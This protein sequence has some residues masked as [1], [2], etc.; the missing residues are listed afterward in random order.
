MSPDLDPQTLLK[1]AE[2]HASRSVRIARS[3]LGKPEIIASRRVFWRR[4]SN[5]M[6]VL[7]P[8][9]LILV[10]AGSMIQTHSAL[11]E[12]RWE[13]TAAAMLLA[14]VLIA[15]ADSCGFYLKPV[16]TSQTVR[17]ELLQL[18]NRSA[19]ARAWHEFV[20]QEGRPLY[21]FDIEIMWALA[22][23]DR[24]DEQNAH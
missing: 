19:G 4:I 6:A 13:I 8:I 5:S 14:G 9:M 1:Q 17:E 20:R 10:I 7:A 24:P 16:D 23:E 21:Q 15:I 3:S 12:T 22:T 2:S 18:E 11:V